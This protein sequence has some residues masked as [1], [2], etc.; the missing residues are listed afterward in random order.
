MSVVCREG[1]T[2]E[3]RSLNSHTF[4]QPLYKHRYSHGTL[5]TIKILD[6]KAISTH[7]HMPLILEW[8]TQRYFARDTPDV[9]LMERR[10]REIYRY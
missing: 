8:G 3:V 1:K 10:P 6:I 7:A 5:C 4:H 9:T 2:C